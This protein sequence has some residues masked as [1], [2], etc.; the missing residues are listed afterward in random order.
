MI[1]NDYEDVDDDAFGD[2]DDDF[3]LGRRCD[4]RWQVF[5]Q[6]DHL[7]RLNSAP[8]NQN[9]RHSNHCHLQNHQHHCCQ[10]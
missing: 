8:D 1:N 5:A 3:V 10:L 6:Y 4:G 2:N 9:H 7:L